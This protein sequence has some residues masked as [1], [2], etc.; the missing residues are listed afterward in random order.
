MTTVPVS[1][2]S[3]LF[4]LG[5]HLGDGVTVR[6]GVLYLRIDGRGVKADTGE[7]IDQP[8][9]AWVLDELEVKGWINC[10]TEPP[11]AT[12]RGVYWLG[13]WT[14]AK[15]GKGRMVRITKGG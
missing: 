3:Y 11:T 14:K 2:L 1:D 15:L 6:D 5:L 4:L 7:V 13:R 9:P 12:E 10:E 8:V